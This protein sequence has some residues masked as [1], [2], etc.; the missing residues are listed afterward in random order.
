MDKRFLRNFFKV[1]LILMVFVIFSV[2][3]IKPAFAAR[4]KKAKTKATEPSIVDFEKKQAMLKQAQEK[5]NNTAWQVRLMRIGEEKKEGFK[6][7]LSFVNNKFAS[8][9]FLKEGFSATNFTLNLKGENLIIWET[10][11]TGPNNDLAN[12]RGEIEGEVMRGVL[13]LHPQK[14]EVKDYSFVSIGKETITKEKAQEIGQQSQGVPEEKPTEL[15]K[16]RRK[17]NGFGKSGRKND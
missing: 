17:R 9:K 5:L 1:L 12:W 15:K 4:Q 16:K 7:E 13:S 2:S 11:Q 14:G 6:D 3:L 8:K 10:M